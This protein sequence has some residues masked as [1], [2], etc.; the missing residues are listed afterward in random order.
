MKKI[1]DYITI[2]EASELL[3]VSEMTLRRWDSSG[4]LKSYRHPFNN[5]RLYA[6]DELQALLRKIND[7]KRGKREP[8]KSI[9]ITPKSLKMNRRMSILITK[10]QETSCGGALN[11]ASYKKLAKKL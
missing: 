11:H 3:G 10:A 2:K 5:Y 7:H 9:K 1:D 8:I 6:K 4:K